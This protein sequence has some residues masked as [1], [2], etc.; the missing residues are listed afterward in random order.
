MHLSRIWGGFQDSKRALDRSFKGTGQ[1]VFGMIWN[2]CSAGKCLE[3]SERCSHFP[4]RHL[5]FKN[6]GLDVF[7]ISM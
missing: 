1:R 2:S 5:G 7:W 6:L 4:R 3:T